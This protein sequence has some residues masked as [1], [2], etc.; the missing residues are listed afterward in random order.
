MSAALVLILVLL[1]VR[2]SHRRLAHA[3]VVQREQETA[4]RVHRR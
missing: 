2:L 1:P 3:V 4:N